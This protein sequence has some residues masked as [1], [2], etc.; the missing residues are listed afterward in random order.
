LHLTKQMEIYSETASNA[1]RFT[2]LIS[3][4]NQLYDVGSGKLPANPFVTITRDKKLAAIQI[5]ELEQERLSVESKLIKSLRVG[6]W[7]V[8]PLIP[9][10]DKL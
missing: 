6:R 4:L 2:Q 7:D 1:T 3:Q 5:V 10:F 8:G 9:I